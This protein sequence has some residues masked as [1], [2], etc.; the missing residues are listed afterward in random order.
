MKPTT[1]LLTRTQ[2][3]WPLR[4]RLSLIVC[5]TPP[6]W[7][8]A[9]ARSTSAR[10]TPNERARYQTQFARIV[11]QLAGL[12]RQ[13]YGTLILAGLLALAVIGRACEV[14]MDIRGIVIFT[15]TLYAILLPALVIQVGMTYDYIA[16]S[17]LLQV[18]CNTEDTQLAQQPASSNVKLPDSFHI[19]P[20]LDASTAI[21]YAEQEVEQLD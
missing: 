10:L 7:V 4:A 2:R 3:N 12:R 20:T 19:R 11:A 5:T 9:T 1:Q 8:V 14:P 21:E 17:A 13:W 6:A 16:A 15:A 18:L